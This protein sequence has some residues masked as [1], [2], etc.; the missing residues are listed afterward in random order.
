MHQIRQSCLL[1]YFLCTLIL[2]HISLP[3]F[4]SGTNLKL[5]NLLVTPKLVKKVITDLNF[6]V[7]YSG[8]L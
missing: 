1:E 7:F 5:H 3:A 4:P 8:K 2:T 6:I